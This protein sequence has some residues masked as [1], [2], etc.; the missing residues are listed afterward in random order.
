MLEHSISS[1]IYSKPRL[2]LLK[3]KPGFDHWVFAD[4]L[5]EN[6]FLREKLFLPKKKIIST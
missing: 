2:V 5:E 6:L 4:I 1:S 3:I